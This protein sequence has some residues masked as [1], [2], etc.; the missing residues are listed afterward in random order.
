MGK[1][2]IRIG[3]GATAFP[4]VRSHEQVQAVMEWKQDEGV[5]EMVCD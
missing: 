2:E 3:V 5:V 4:P 1:E